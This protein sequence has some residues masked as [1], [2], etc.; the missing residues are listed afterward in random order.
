M[1]IILYTVN[2]EPIT[3][4]ELP[5]QVVEKM[6]KDGGIKLKLEHTQQECVVLVKKIEW[7]D[8]EPKNVYVA[9]NEESALAMKPGWL[10]GQIG[11]IQRMKKDV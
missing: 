3:C 8:G 2:F 11:T 5:S 9:L 10:P 1:V 4:L 7:P 6:H